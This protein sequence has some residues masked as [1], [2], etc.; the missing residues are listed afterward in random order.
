[1]D[2]SIA[3][4]GGDDFEDHSVSKSLIR[5]LTN[6]LMLIYIFLGLLIYVLMRFMFGFC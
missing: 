1:M 6:L 2:K 3:Q 4:V 5:K